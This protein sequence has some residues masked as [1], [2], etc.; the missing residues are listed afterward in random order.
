[1]PMLAEGYV[2]GSAGKACSVMLRF[3]Y[4]TKI[5]KPLLN[6]YWNRFYKQ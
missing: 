2:K 6:S 3:T 1:M 5:K 4:I